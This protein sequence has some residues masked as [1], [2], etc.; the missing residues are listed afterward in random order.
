VFSR[1]IAEWMT[2]C[3]SSALQLLQREVALISRA[4]TA[5][6]M[7][8]PEMALA[9]LRP[10]KCCLQGMQPTVEHMT[11]LHAAYLQA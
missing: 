1:L 10:L 5:H 3:P 8:H 6:A 11:P 2:I 4:F 9:A 7:Q